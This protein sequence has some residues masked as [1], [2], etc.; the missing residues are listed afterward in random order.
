[1]FT[2]S[3][4]TCSKSLTVKSLPE[5]PFRP[6]CSQRCKLI[7]LARW[8]NEEYRIEVARPEKPEETPVEAA[9]DD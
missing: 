3:C 1:M 7:D 2:F 6:F 5:A 8:F 9:G 4:P